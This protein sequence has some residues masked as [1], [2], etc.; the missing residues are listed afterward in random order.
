MQSQF[1]APPGKDPE[2][3]VEIP[4]LE[5][6]VEVR[7]R[8]LWRAIMAFEAIAHSFGIETGSETA[9]QP[10]Q[11]MVLIHSELFNAAKRAT[12]A[13]DLRNERQRRRNDYD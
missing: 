4:Q 11:E 12:S 8:K 5:N 3:F 6:I 10:E 1:F 2:S 13:Q 9:G 7:D